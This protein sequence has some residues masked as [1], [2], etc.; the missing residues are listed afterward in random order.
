M[1]KVLAIALAVVLLITIATPTLAAFDSGWLYELLDL[2]GGT[3]YY[4]DSVSGDDSN[5][6]ESEEQAWK[7]LE[8]VNSFVFSPGDKILFKSGCVFI[9]QLMPQ[10]SGNAEDGS[11]I[12][13][14]YGSGAQP[15][16]DA[17]GTT[18][19]DGAVI[20]LYNQEYI[21]ISDLELTNNSSVPG[22]RYGVYVIAEDYG[23]ADHIYVTNCNV[24]D[25]P[26][27]AR[28]ESVISMVANGG[29]ADYLSSHGSANGGIIYAALCGGAEIPTAFNDVFIDGNTVS[30]TGVTGTGIGVTS[31]WSML[32]GYEGSV[33]QEGY[34]DYKPFFGSTNILISNNN[35]SHTTNAIRFAGVDGRVGNGAIAEHNIAYKP[36][37]GDSN[38]AMWANNSYDI[39]WQYNEIYGLDNGGMND[40]GAFDADGYSRN[41]IFQYNY[42]HDNRGEP[43]MFCNVGW[44][45]DYDYTNTIGSIYRYNISQNDMW[46][47][48]EGHGRFWIQKGAKDNWLY[49][50]VVYVG[51]GLK[52]RNISIAETWE[53]YIFNNIFIN[54]SDKTT[55]YNESPNETIVQNN[56]FYGYHP[57]SEPSKDKSNIIM[58]LDDEMPLIDPG[59]GEVGLDTLSGYMLKAD[60]PLVGAGKL[61]ENNGGKDFYGNTVSSSKAP[62]IG[63]HQTASSE[64]TKAPEKVSGL[65][66]ETHGYDEISVSWNTTEDNVG[67]ERYVV[68]VNGKP[69]GRTTDTKWVATE[70]KPDTKYSFF[71]RAFDAAG[72]SSDSETV[73]VKTEHADN[74]D[75]KLHISSA[76][77]YDING[78]KATSFNGAEFIASRFK[79]VNGNGE[80]VENALVK[81]LVSADSQSDYETFTDMTDKNGIAQIGFYADNYRG[82]KTKLVVKVTDIYK[83]DYTYDSGHS[84]N[85]DSVKINV[86]GADTKYYANLV[87]NPDFSLVYEGTN[88]P[89]S[90]GVATGGGLDAVRVVD[91]IGMEGDSV[92]EFSENENFTSLA[93][94]NYTDLPNGVYTLTYYVKNTANSASV[95]LSGYGSSVTESI[96]I[97][98][99]WQQVSVSDINV[100]TGKIS[101]QFDV[102]GDA[103]TITYLD[104]VE[105]SQNLITNTL[106]TEVHP[107]SKLPQDYYYSTENGKIGEDGSNV[108][109]LLDDSSIK[110]VNIEKHYT[111]SYNNVLRIGGDEPFKV[112][113][114]Q[115]LKNVAKGI[116]TLKVDT[117]NTGGIKAF[118]VIKEH[119]GKEISQEIKMSSGMKSTKI[120]GVEVTSGKAVVEL[121]FEGK[122]DKEEYIL[123]KG[124]SFSA[125]SD[126]PINAAAITFAGDNLL[127]SQN[128]SFEND[129]R[130]TASLPTSWV[131]TWDQGKHSCFATDEEA[132]SGDYSCKIILHHDQQI[133]SESGSKATSL[134][135]KPNSHTF[136]GLATG[137]YTFSLWASQR[138]PIGFSGDT[139]IAWETLD[140]QPYFTVTASNL[141]Y[142]WWSH[143]IGGHCGGDRDDELSLRWVQFGVF[144]PIF[145]LHS[146]CNPFLGREPWNYNSRAEGIISDYMRLRHQL[147]PYLYSM[148]YRSYKKQLPLMLPMYY[149]HPE[150]KEAYEVKNQYW[151]GSELIVCPVTKKA[152]S[153][154]GL[155]FS[156]VW[157]PEG[158]W[159]DWFNGYVYKGNM[160]FECFRSLEQMPIFCKA[161]AII[162]MQKHIEHENKLCPAK[163]IELVIA[164]GGNGEFT[165]FEDDGIST[166]YE[167]GK[168]AF[169]TYKFNW[170]ENSAELVIGAAK[171][172]LE[173]IPQ[174]RN[175]ALEFKGFKK[176]CVFYLGGNLLE[177][178]Y[179]AETNSYMVSIN[180]VESKKGAVIC[181]KCEN[182][183]LHDNSDYMHRCYKMLLYSQTTAAIRDK[184]Y[185]FADSLQHKIRW[186]PEPIGDN[187]MTRAF[188]ELALQ[189]GK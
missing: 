180:G 179:D 3:S 87:R 49:N 96:P 80:P 159:I 148:N 98:P 155:G 113:V 101:L 154:S 84:K 64:D 89:M 54:L 85:H 57:K 125:R 20:R 29:E 31:E 188:Y 126:Y 151:F 185:T 147:F 10:G 167:L 27:N 157:L 40:C 95:T 124:L 165:M 14:S 66:T 153:E 135:L 1:K 35:L 60:S 78:K 55:Y 136:T 170:E 118:L 15:V 119:G 130:T 108:E 73:N 38:S 152:D 44:R 47:A 145:R 134:N 71:V 19:N 22:V 146:S 149:T 176:G 137:Y 11:I 86:I 186:K 32:V 106:Y 182:G 150:N 160:S 99:K 92:L 156:E 128:P 2:G 43:V 129:G 138:F 110:A 173:L 53:N 50:N 36:D 166:D 75:L 111:E 171:G 107:Y 174:N 16:I 90:W 9:G 67:I 140:F 139:Y 58:D 93:I 33:M 131:N 77:V 158:K 12:I 52:G 7:T 143:D 21:E 25:V 41:T 115:T 91:G 28:K 184:L 62:D 97:S 13:S 81:V 94:Q 117:I 26:S 4:V 6:G 175:Y 121:R 70:L 123:L 181:I 79:V 37:N 172:D 177:A 65:K 63:V 161:G 17:N 46:G 105:L 8:K 127:A 48:N 23:V 187:M 74:K 133:N 51:E 109:K 168:G 72:L 141:G 59:K 142:G 39:V 103:S 144:S 56:C 163:D 5:S 132:H 18:E 122:G 82:E 169:T 162:P 45:E 42:T 112:S 24:H 102:A 61:I 34:L 164:A 76:G 100:T 69:L 178:K 114:G 189:L 68:Y 104:K 88:I 120:S 30:K 183:L 83:D 116:Y